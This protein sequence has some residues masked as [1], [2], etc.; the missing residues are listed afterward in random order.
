MVVEK[1]IRVNIILERND[2]KDMPNQSNIVVTIEYLAGLYPYPMNASFPIENLWD[3]I[4]T[5]NITPDDDIYLGEGLTVDKDGNVVEVGIAVD[6]DGN[7]IEN[8]PPP[9]NVLARLNTTDT[10]K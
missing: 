1:E 10:V 9:P 8:A 5:M 2:W 6:K 4:C 7:F 3:A